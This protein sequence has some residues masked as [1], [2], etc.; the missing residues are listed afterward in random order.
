[1][2]KRKE[3]LILNV[4]IDPITSC[5]N[6]KKGKDAAGYGTTS[7]KGKRMMVHR[8]SFIFFKGEIEERA[9]ICHTCDNPPCCNPDHLW[10]G[11]HQDNS[12]DMIAKGRAKHAFGD[13]HPR[14]KITSI[15][16]LDVYNRHLDGQIPKEISLATGVPQGSI[17]GIC[18]GIT[19]KC[20]RN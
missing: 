7:F 13:A 8:L 18:R 17:S 19:W 15:Q 10:Q 12:N 6:W 4:D 5:W 20:I 9:S 2:I 14:S 3:D 11:Y 1:M 16:A